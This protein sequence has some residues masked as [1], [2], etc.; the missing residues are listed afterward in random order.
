MSSRATAEMEKIRVLIVDDEPVAREGIRVLLED[1][2]DI[3]IVGEC[4]DGEE[5]AR[6]IADLEPDLVF[7]D[8]QMPEMDGFAVLERV[9]PEEMPVVVFVTAYDQYAL[10]AFDVAAVDYLLKPY[11]D[12]RFSAALARAKSHV[13][14]E[15]M[16]AL[17]RR[18]IALL[19]AQ[20]KAPAGAPSTA[21][22]TGAAPRYLDRVLIKTGGK[23]L[24]LKVEEVDWIEAEGDYV[25]LHVGGEPHLLRDT[26]KRLE[27]QLDPKR[28]LRVH[29]SAIVNLDRVK[30]LHPYF[31][32]DYM[33]RL[34]DGTE[35][36]LSRTRRQ[37]LEQRLGRKL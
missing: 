24:F 4:S 29:R 3:E 9:G 18:L 27:R 21:E 37:Q 20:S 19:E 25:K 6:V 34:Q 30:E 26:M 16:G 10:K 31:H 12:E 5:A 23:V 11:D 35:I 36:K 1:D 13:R 33:I 32:G 2:E 8:I 14:Q 7:L 22:P 15:E 17:S 28:F